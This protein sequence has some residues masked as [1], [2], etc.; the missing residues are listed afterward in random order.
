MS[1]NAFK[2]ASDYDKTVYGTW[3]LSF[4]EIER[5]QGDYLVMEMHKQPRL[6]FGS[7]TFVLSII[8]VIFLETYSNLLLRSLQNMLLIRRQM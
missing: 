3:D 2:G 8:I 7:S 6:Q 4:K 1:D 5:E